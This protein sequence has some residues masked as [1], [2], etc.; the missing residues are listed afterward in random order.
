MLYDSSTDIQS[1]FEMDVYRKR[2]AAALFTFLTLTSLRSQ[3][4][5][6]LGQLLQVESNEKEEQRKKRKREHELMDNMQNMVPPHSAPT[7]PIPY[8]NRFGVLMA[9]PNRQYV[10]RLTHMYSWEIVELAE[11]LKPYISAPRTTSWRPTPKN[12][13]GLKRGKPPKYDP[14]NRL[15]FTLEWLSSGSDIIRSEIENS[16]SKTSC[17]EDLKHVLRAINTGLADHI[18]EHCSA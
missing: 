5:V 7:I 3:R 13:P 14:I 15:L 12:P 11:L 4:L 16:Y 10:K 9:D 1:L 8:R 6:V 2:I 17:H 18:T